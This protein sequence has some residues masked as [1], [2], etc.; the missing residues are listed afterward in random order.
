MQ[1][2]EVEH[3]VDLGQPAGGEKEKAAG[4][5]A[6]AFRQGS[7]GRRNDSAFPKLTEDELR[8]GARF[9]VGR[10]SMRGEKSRTEAARRQHNLSARI[11][12]MKKL[13]AVIV[14]ALVTA[15]TVWVIG[16]IQ[17]ANR[18]AT[19]PELLPETTLALI[20]VPDFQRART[21]WQRSDLCQ[22]WHE[23]TVQAWLQKPLAQSA[24][25]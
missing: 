14:V 16:R 7:F 8:T 1:T 18:L 24:A 3:F 6:A 13:L 17:L 9:H 19:V 12:A 25:G 22:I 10:S 11:C 4:R 15:A 21:Q 2:D 23:P 5:L 20:E